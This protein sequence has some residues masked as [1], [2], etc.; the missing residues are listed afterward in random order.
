MAGMEVIDHQTVGSGGA[1]SISFTSIPDTYRHLYVVG[2]FRSDASTARF[3]G[4]SVT[5]NDDTG[6]NYSYSALFTTGNA[7]IGTEETG[8]PNL[9]YL[10]TANA[11][12]SV[13]NAFAA[14]SMWVL[15]YAATD[16]F[17]GVI[18]GASAVNDNLDTSDY[19]EGLISGHWKSTA[20]VNKITI[21]SGSGN[22]VQ[23]SE[24]TL[25]GL[26]SAS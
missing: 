21:A 5:F 2:S 8:R 22:Y 11:S 17:T 18:G 6:S 1:S 9:N 23:Y 3:S 25:Y 13:A 24:A 19:F 15:D 20:A 14:G 10:F 12:G 7:P 16:K 4:D 26:N